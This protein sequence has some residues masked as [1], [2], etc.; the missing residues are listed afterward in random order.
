MK[1]TKI[2]S[3]ATASVITLS[4]MTI[5]T[6]ALDWRDGVRASH[7]YTYE[8]SDEGI[9]NV[10]VQD[11]NNTINGVVTQGQS[12]KSQTGT[13]TWRD[14]YENVTAFYVDVKPGYDVKV[15]VNGE[16]GEIYDANTSHEVKV[17]SDLGK[18]HTYT[19]DEKDGY[20]KVFYFSS[21][22][23]EAWVKNPK[24]ALKTEKITYQVV[25]NDGDS[26]GTATV[27]ENSID[28]SSLNRKGYRIST[29]YINGVKWNGKDKITSEM[30][31]ASQNNQLVVTAEY[32]VNQ[33]TLTVNY[34]NDRVSGKPIMTSQSTVRY[35][36]VLTKESLKLADNQY[37]V[38][39]NALT[40]PDEDIT[41]NVVTRPDEQ[42]FG[43]YEWGFTYTGTNDPHIQQVVAQWNWDDSTNAPIQLNETVRLNTGANLHKYHMKF[44]VLVDKGYRV[45]GT[46]LSD[47]SQFDAVLSAEAENYDL[48]EIEYTRQAHHGM[49]SAPVIESFALETVEAN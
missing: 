25:N 39:T 45:T 14:S 32:V 46:N 23:K 38:G 27:D 28:L 42:D 4:V 47:D 35:N 10:Y 7:T 44:F 24:F 3:A 33:H 41:L 20:D 34:Y 36:D 13:I 9:E 6:F 48:Y 43:T 1:K 26:L 8:Y 40:V 12:I 2:I 18:D 37:I 15:S 11:K 16:D 17:D 5:P 49:Y 19:I 31:E 29:Y 22:G 30:I 21:A